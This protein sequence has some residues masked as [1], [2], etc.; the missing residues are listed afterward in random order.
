MKRALVLLVAITGAAGCAPWLPRYAPPAGTRETGFYADR[1]RP[2]LALL[3]YRI[4]DY[5][6]HDSRTYATICAARTNMKPHDPASRPVA[7]DADVETALRSRF[8]ALSPLS[9]CERAGIGFKD[10]ATGAPAAVFDAHDT[11]CQP[12]GTCVGWAGYVA[13]GPHGWRYYAMEYRDGAWRIRPEKL[14]IILTGDGAS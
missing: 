8:P 11:V 6:A 14:D 7:L 9:Q 4:A 5:L 2:E 1:N 13:D 3:E 10:R 12:N